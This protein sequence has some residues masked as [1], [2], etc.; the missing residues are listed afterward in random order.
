[1]KI[2]PLQGYKSLRALNGCHALLLGLKMLPAYINESYEAFY[3]RFQEKSD[4]EKETLLR[5]AAVFVQLSQDEVEAIISFATDKNGVPYGPSNMKSLP[6]NEIH[7]I[8]V[9]VCMEIGRF[10]ID[11]LSE[12]EKKNFPTSQ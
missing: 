4:P 7:E 6:V 3:K 11:L 10:K 1:M 2:L 9:A 5:E 12:E 8:I